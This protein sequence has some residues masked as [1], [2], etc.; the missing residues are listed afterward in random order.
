M[1]FMAIWPNGGSA[2]II[3]VEKVENVEN[4]IVI[5]L[6]QK[7]NRL[8]YNPLRLAR[9]GQPQIC[10]IIDHSGGMIMKK[11]QKMMLLTQAALLMLL[12]ATAAWGSVENGI[13]NNSREDVDLSLSGYYKEG[14]AYNEIRLGS[15]SVNLVGDVNLG[16]AGPTVMRRTTM[17]RL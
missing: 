3:I 4:V 1:P 6:F 9:E 12:A 5:P 10:F 16:G 11:F 13:L 2:P 17:M 8:M 15:S 7:A 14:T